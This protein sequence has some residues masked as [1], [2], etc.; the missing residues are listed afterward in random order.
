MSKINAAH[1]EHTQIKTRGSSA[2]VKI[3]TLLNV[4]FHRGRSE[5]VCSLYLCSIY[6]LSALAL[7]V[8]LL[9]AGVFVFRVIVHY[10]GKNAEMYRLKFGSPVL[11]HLCGSQMRCWEFV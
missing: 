3:W 4:A 7:A 11:I 8:I 5:C 6:Y 9:T 2:G 10:C 1:H